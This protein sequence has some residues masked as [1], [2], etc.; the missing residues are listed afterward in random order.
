[1]SDVRRTL[2]SFTM[3]VPFNDAP[4]AGADYVRRHYQTL[5]SDY[6]IH[7]VAEMTDQNVC[8]AG[9]AESAA[10]NVI[11]VDRPPWAKNIVGKA[12]LRIIYELLP[13]SLNQ[14]YVRAA[15]RD[16]RVQEVL[17]SADVVEFQWTENF[18]FTRIARRHAP[19]GTRLI[20]IAH[21]VL[22]QRDERRRL[23]AAWTR[24][25][26]PFV[27]KLLAARERGLL[28]GLDVAI[29]FSDKDRVLVDALHANVSSKVVRPGLGTAGVIEEFG[30]LAGVGLPKVL[31]VGAYDRPENEEAALWLLKDIW[32]SVLELTDTAELWLVGANPTVSMLEAAKSSVRV[33][34]TGFVPSIDAFYRESAVVVVPLLRGAG[35]KFKTVT[36]MLWGKPIVATPVGAEGTGPP[37]CFYLISDSRAAIAAAIGELCSDPERGRRVA[38]TAFMYANREYSQSA[39]AAS[40]IRLYS[41]EMQE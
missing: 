7:V 18:V 28:R 20:G 40:L 15:S 5:G 17:S 3:Q 24:P 37:E 29:V 9:L 32:P 22:T 2:V 35:L 13:F 34:V 1:M 21:D 39:Y 23:S 6:S 14:A 12:I 31:F 26:R 41:C 33:N 4:N 11:L 19:V 30:R 38:R 16:P 8:A 25:L 10:S 36:A 27:R